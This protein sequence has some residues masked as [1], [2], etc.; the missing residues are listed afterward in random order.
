MNDFEAAGG[1]IVLG[2]VTMDQL[3]NIATDSD[4]TLLAAGKGEIGQVV[5]RDTERSVYDKPQ[6]NLFMVIVEGVDAPAGDRVE[7]NPVKFNFFADAGEYFWVPYTHKSGKHT[8][9]VLFEAK[10]GGYLDKFGDVTDAQSAV[11]AAKAVIKEY[12]PYEYEYV[13]DMYPVEGDPHCWLKGRFPP[14]VRQAFGKAP[15]G[16]TIVPIGDSAILFDPIGG[17]G[18]NC[19]QKNTWHWAEALIQR[20]DEAYDEAWISE[21]REDFWVKHGWAAYT[22]N[23][24]LLEPLTDSGREIL[25]YASQDRVFADTAFLGNFHAPVNFFPWFVDVDAAKTK[26]AQYQR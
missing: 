25:G 22:F 16:G 11:D 23:N 8:W 13:K 3:D 2:E 19:A 9:C 10:P 1:K 21:V 12:A 17:Q 4:L 5:P 6:R 18:G 15:S 20:G 7:F 26:I 14:T 24:I